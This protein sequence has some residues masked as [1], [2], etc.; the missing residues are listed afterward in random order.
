MAH[1]WCPG[2]GVYIHEVVPQL[3]VFQFADKVDVRRMVGGGPWAYENHLLLF[4]RL[5]PGEDPESIVLNK[6]NL[7]IQVHNLPPGFMSEVVAKHIGKK[8][9]G[10]IKADPNS[11][12]SS[13]RGFMQVRVSINVN[14]PLKKSM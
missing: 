11:Y 13:W 4:Q 8:L 7:W 14:R 3:F 6:V 9:G 5:Q 10:F 12:T 2:K 1:N